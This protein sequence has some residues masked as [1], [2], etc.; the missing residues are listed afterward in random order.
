MQATLYQEGISFGLL[1][2][3]RTGLECAVVASW[4]RLVQNRLIS[5]D[6]VGDDNHCA[7]KRSHFGVLRVHLKNFVIQNCLLPDIPTL[8][9]F[10]SCTLL[11]SL[12]INVIIQIAAQ[13]IRLSETKRKLLY[14]LQWIASTQGLEN[15]YVSATRNHYVKC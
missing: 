2:P 14:I 13:I 6:V 15:F 5:L 10:C 4:I 11:K 8:A 12:R 9:H 7:A 3:G 1:G